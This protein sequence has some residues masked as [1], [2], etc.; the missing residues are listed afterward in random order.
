M[1]LH[2]P[3][4]RAALALSVASCAL[5][6]LLAASCAGRLEVDPEPREVGGA[7]GG[8]SPDAGDPDAKPDAKPSKLDGGKDSSPDA[9]DAPDALPD[10]VDPGCPDAGPPTTLYECDP[11]GD[12]C[13]EGKSCYPFVDYPSE[14]CGQEIF[15]ASCIFSGTSGQG[16]PCGIGCK[17]GHVCVISG[18]GTQCVR[19]CDLKE[20]NPCKDGLLCVPVDIPGIG[21][22]I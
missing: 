16:E 4:R 1:A 9:P 22:C 2:H 21:G 10:Y 3:A 20:P 14:P 13:G 7:G 8:G 12:D 18:Q 15:G 11:Y 6:L 19:L 5:S 17:A